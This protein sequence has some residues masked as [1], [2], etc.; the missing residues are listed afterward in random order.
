[1]PDGRELNFGSI[2]R[3]E[4]PRKLNFGAIPFEEA[5]APSFL[6][7]AQGFIEDPA[8]LAR[9]GAKKVLPEAV[10]QAHEYASDKMGKGL[11]FL[12]EQPLVPLRKGLDYVL[13]ETK[14]LPEG[15]RLPLPGI[16]GTPSIPAR[17]AAGALRGTANIAESFTTGENLAIL[18]ATAGGSSALQ[19]AKSALARY[20]PAAVD[21]IFGALALQHA[22]EAWQAYKDAPPEEKTERLVEAVGSIGLGLMAGLGAKERIKQGR[23]AG[24]QLKLKETKNR[25]AEEEALKA[26][27]ETLRVENEKE[28]LRERLQKERDLEAGGEIIGESKGKI[29][30]VSEV[31]ADIRKR[32]TE[33]P[34]EQ[35]PSDP[36]LRELLDE[37]TLQRRLAG[38]DRFDLSEFKE[39]K[40]IET[41]AQA[42]KVEPTKLPASERELR[43]Q[44]LPSNLSDGKANSASFKS[45]LDDFIKVQGE[46]KGKP[47]SEQ[48]A[49][50]KTR[51]EEKGYHPAIVDELTAPE[52]LKRPEIEG[53]VSE[54]TTRPGRLKRAVE[55]PPELKEK[56]DLVADK[57]AKFRDAEA[58][59]N[60]GREEIFKEVEKLGGKII[61]DSTDGTFKIEIK[62]G[63]AKL[64]MQDQLALVKLK[65]EAAEAGAYSLATLGKGFQIAAAPLRI[66]QGESLRGSLAEKVSEFISRKKALKAA[67]SNF[68]KSEKAL[69]DPYTDF[70]FKNKLEGKEN[71]SLIGRGA[72]RPVEVQ[73]R[74]K[75]SDTLPD[76]PKAR[77]KI[78]EARKEMQKRAQELGPQGEPFV[79]TRK[80]GTVR[81]EAE[82]AAG[83]SFLDITRNLSESETAALNASRERLKLAK[84]EYR[85]ELSGSLL[86]PTVPI[87]PKAWKEYVEIGYYVGKGLARNLGE[88]SKVTFEHFKESL[89]NQ[90]GDLYKKIEPHVALLWD[91]IKALPENW[92]PGDEIPKLK[93]AEHVAAPTTPERIA[94]QERR[95]N[96]GLPLIERLANTNSEGA[97]LASAWNKANNILK[98]TLGRGAV[99]I[100]NFA[101]EAGLRRDETTPHLDVV[102]PARDKRLGANLL[103]ADMINNPE[104]RKNYPLTDLEKRILAFWDKTHIAQEKEAAPLLGKEPDL[105][106]KFT[107]TLNNE[108]R[109]AI[110]VQKGGPLFEAFVNT[111]SARSGIPREKVEAKVLRGDLS[112]LDIPTHLYVKDQLVSIGSADAISALQAQNFEHARTM[113][114]LKTFGSQPKKAVAE[115]RKEYMSKPGADG[116]VFDRTRDAYFGLRPRDSISTLQNSRSRVARLLF[117]T[118]DPIFSSLAL[119]TSAPLQLSQPLMDLRSVGWKNMLKTYR[120]LFKRELSGDDLERMGVTN[121][122]VLNLKSSEGEKLEDYGK[123]ISALVNRFDGMEGA[124]LLNDAVSATHWRHYV[125]SLK[126]KVSS[127]KGL[128]AKDKQTLKTD[129]GVTDTELARIEQGKFEDPL[130]KNPATP[131]QE[132]FVQLVRQGKTG[133]QHTGKLGVERSKFQTSPAAQFWL[134]FQ[135]YTIGE[136]QRWRRETANLQR[137]HKS[138]SR[139]EKAEAW[140][141]FG[142]LL[143]TTALQGEIINLIRHTIKGEWDEADEDSAVMQLAEGNYGKAAKNFL[144]NTAEAGFMGPFT[145]AYLTFQIAGRGIEALADSFLP[146]NILHEL[147]DL[148]FEKGKYSDKT[149]TEKLGT[150]WESRIPALRNYP[151]ALTRSLALVDLAKED[152][153]KTD[154]AIRSYY[155]WL[156]DTKRGQRPPEKEGYLESRRN[157]LLAYRAYNNGD[158]EDVM[159]LLMQGFDAKIAENPYMKPKE[160]L[161]RIK[162][163][164]RGHIKVLK[165]DPNSDYRMVSKYDPKTTDDLIKKIGQEK[166]D[167][168]V[169][170]DQRLKRLLDSL[171][172]TRAHLQRLR[173]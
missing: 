54:A 3:A 63:K 147:I 32:L 136:F 38:E 21:A 37:R 44:T 109:E 85:E 90:L 164:L 9:Y 17:E 52:R 128:S 119:S 11:K 167:L 82:K 47:L 35:I 81:A 151:K 112:G 25:L 93:R 170:H 153:R 127:G 139:G 20:A 64:S 74:R 42:P 133:S 108:M 126:E 117:R 137:A 121:R 61:V 23:E 60:K 66:K 168:L 34:E 53:D 4:Q 131:E 132:L 92:K 78:V 154:F 161:E 84:Q 87:N 2:P 157:F 39:A 94:E 115:L 172:V 102:N 73:L 68:R 173:K 56:V 141:R 57:A 99:E 104:L 83:T 152:G 8:A 14:N 91:Q 95:W 33:I 79:E 12:R 86:S 43:A 6:D 140:K 45:A 105:R 144:W 31:E 18:L 98:T 89:K 62:P 29:R 10:I 106:P 1:M 113:G 40:P 169:E 159:P 162:D 163:S 77:Q 135:S 36:K 129:L 69:V 116:Q 71:A 146:T 160:A 76:E 26:R 28:V 88:F 19:G 59:Y 114:L 111:V 118:V 7:K 65:Q 30:K 110:Y 101:K 155:D 13:P 158:D 70:Y 16:P 41:P 145:R 22:P 123:I 46:T 142:K 55:P 130:G 24:R 156:D 124:A 103:F 51:L 96:F 100:R 138:G 166:Y 107:P 125:N 48:L 67:Q 50:A 122:S 27:T 149:F 80:V 75:P 5:P 171:V 49:T 97:K 150:F 143:G 120:D 72:D 165:N 58:N 134:K 148:G 15:V